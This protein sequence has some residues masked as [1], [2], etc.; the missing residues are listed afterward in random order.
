MLVHQITPELLSLQEVAG[1]YFVLVTISEVVD[2]GAVKV[3]IMTLL[4]T[5]V[6]RT[7]VMF[8]GAEDT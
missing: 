4:K 7:V 6:L 3:M 5:T 2:T 1:T 8:N